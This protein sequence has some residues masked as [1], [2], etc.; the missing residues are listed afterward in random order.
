MCPIDVYVGGTDHLG[1]TSSG[2]SMLWYSSYM[3]CWSGDEQ[4]IATVI[5]NAQ[6]FLEQKR[7]LFPGDSFDVKLVD[8][9]ILTIYR[10]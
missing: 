1:Q 10:T 2:L 4:G 8:G 7:L 5:D 6:G 3:V 9:K